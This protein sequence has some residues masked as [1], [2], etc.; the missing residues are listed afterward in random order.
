MSDIGTEVS[1]SIP[2]GPIEA[3]PLDPT[4]VQVRTRPP[5]I[6][7]LAPFI[8]PSALHRPHPLRSLAPSP[9]PLP[10]PSHWLVLTAP[11]FLAQSQCLSLIAICLPISAPSGS[12]LH[13]I[14]SPFPVVEIHRC[15]PPPPPSALPPSA[16]AI[17]LAPL[18]SRHC[19]PCSSQEALPSEPPLP[20]KR[21]PSDADVD[22]M[23]DSLLKGLLADALDKMCEG[24]TEQGARLSLLTA[25]V[26][27]GSPELRVSV[28]RG[29]LDAA[30]PASPSPTSASPSSPKANGALLRGA[31]LPLPAFPQGRRSDDGG[32]PSARPQANQQRRTLR[33]SR[34]RPR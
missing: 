7:S 32:H 19:P 30:V 2:S 34:A 3:P 24:Y 6:A 22:T 31:V 1:G 33:I 11:R 8:T 12:R 10:A 4:D 9:P 16:W 5:S 25:S 15:P 28:G 21:A 13:F 20:K 29:G 27:Q 17:P 14:L 23:T 18:A 26:K